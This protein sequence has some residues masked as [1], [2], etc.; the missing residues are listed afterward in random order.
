M[1]Y[2]LRPK[3]KPDTVAL[4]LGRLPGADSTAI[5]ALVTGGAYL[6]A[7]EV[8]AAHDQVQT[9][10]FI[11]TTYRAQKLR[12]AGPLLK[13]PKFA[14]GCIVTTNFDDA[15]EKTYER[16]S[17]EFKAYMHGTQ[18][19]NFFQRLV[20]G[21]RCLLK[22]HGDAEND[23]THILTKTQYE[24]AYG[25]PFDFQKP[26]PKALRQIYISQSLFFLG[27]SLDQDWIMELFKT[28][29]AGDGYQVPI[30]YALL[31]A[32]VDAQAKQQKETRL[33]AL[34]IHLIWYPDGQYELIERILD[35]IVDVADKRVVFA[36]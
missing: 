4:L 5:N 1:D 27:C 2:L 8:L 33:L 11:R 13:L 32:P 25:E 12:L 10:H 9:S 16:N 35:L 18:E 29:N 3:F 36:G 7:A 22:L 24:E 28:A 15:I 17:I 19:H 31:A 23:A 30:H 6:E 20:R 34:N 26:L 21:D 14:K